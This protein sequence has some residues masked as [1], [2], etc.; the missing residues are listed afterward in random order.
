MLKYAKVVDGIVE[1][2][3]VADIEFVE[4]NCRE[5]IPADDFV[6]VGDKYEDGKFIKVS[7]PVIDE[8]AAE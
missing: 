2:I 7:I 1:N 3:F 8:L 5:A 6:G 4:A